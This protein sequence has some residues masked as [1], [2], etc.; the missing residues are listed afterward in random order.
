MA[1][2][3]RPA[4][5]QQIPQASRNKLRIFLATWARMTT[6]EQK[7]RKFT[8]IGIKG[9]PLS[10]SIVQIDDRD[11]PN[12]WT[13]HGSNIWC[14]PSCQQNWRGKKQK[15]T[16]W[17]A[18]QSQNDHCTLPNVPNHG[19]LLC[20]I[21]L[22]AV[23]SY[24]HQQQLQWGRTVVA[25]SIALLHAL[26]MQIAACIWQIVKLWFNSAHVHVACDASMNCVEC[27][28]RTEGTT[29]LLH[30]ASYKISW[31]KG[32]HCPDV[33]T[34]QLSNKHCILTRVG[35]LSKNDPM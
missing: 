13:S 8:S 20:S 11:L 4:M 24:Q 34:M 17:Y 21:G 12:V 15:D 1:R 27:T 14:L 31:Y 19:I 22:Q 7:G 30:C 16:D 33:R 9:E 18:K 3:G 32:M 29:T 25:E 35:L 5:H 26:E 10:S 2:Q 23:R 28:Q 6:K